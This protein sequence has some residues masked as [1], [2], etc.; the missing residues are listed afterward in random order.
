MPGP[1]WAAVD[2]PEAEEN[3]KSGDRASAGMRPSSSTLT[4]PHTQRGTWPGPVLSP[5]STAQLGGES[6]ALG[7]GWPPLPHL[8]DLPYY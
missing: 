2:I 6:S 7:P 8:S 5:R 4:G 3:V 1:W